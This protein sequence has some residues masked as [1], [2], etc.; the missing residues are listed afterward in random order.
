MAAE[1]EE[2]DQDDFT[3]EITQYLC[4]YKFYIDLVSNQYKY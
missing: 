4:R 3:S 1:A 2:A